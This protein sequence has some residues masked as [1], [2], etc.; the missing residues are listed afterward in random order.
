MRDHERDSPA[1]GAPASEQPWSEQPALSPELRAVLACAEAVVDRGR[2]DAFYA[3][4]GACRSAEALC[5]A[6]VAQGML[7]H[8]R[9]AVT[10]APASVAAARTGHAAR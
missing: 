8:L 5:A 7:G 4:L 1:A 2:L 6:A 10:A 3:A 9:A